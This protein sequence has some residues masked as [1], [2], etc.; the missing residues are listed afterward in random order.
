[1]KS[2][3]N[4]ATLKILMM[5]NSIPYPRLGRKSHG[6]SEKLQSSMHSRT[7]FLRKTTMQR[8]SLLSFRQLTWSILLGRVI[9]LGPT[10]SSQ[11]VKMLLLISDLKVDQEGQ[12]RGAEMCL[13]TGTLYK[14]CQTDSPK[15]WDQA[16]LA[17]ATQESGHWKVQVVLTPT[18]AVLEQ[19][20]PAVTTSQSELTK[21]LH[22]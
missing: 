14:G 10:A 5:T 20:G 15:S 3:R 7:L 12:T 8:K 16:P 4:K 21:M 18:V 13:F 6:A 22:S 1:M 2:C 9:Q 19:Q 11:A 17:L